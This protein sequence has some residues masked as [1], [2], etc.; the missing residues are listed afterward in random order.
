MIISPQHLYKLETG[1]IPAHE[2]EYE[3]YIWRS[4]GQWVIDITDEEK[5]R[6]W[7]NRGVIEITKPDEDYV[8][9]LEEKVMELLNQ[10]NNQ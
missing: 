1:S 2:I 3:F 4:K 7:G 8:R 6:I 9:W 5:F 10:I